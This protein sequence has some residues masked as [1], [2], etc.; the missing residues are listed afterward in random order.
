MVGNFRGVLIF[1]DFMCS[2]YPQKLLNFSYR[3]DMPQKYK[4]TKSSKLPKPQK[5]DPRKLQTIW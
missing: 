4:P 1:M 5:L 3:V 2:A